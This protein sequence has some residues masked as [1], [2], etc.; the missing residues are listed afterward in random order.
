MLNVLDNEPF[1]GED[2]DAEP[3]F[4]VDLAALEAELDPVGRGEV[5]GL[6][7]VEAGGEAG[8]VGAWQSEDKFTWLL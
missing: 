4:A 7:D 6:A 8:V 2:R 3:G 5:D 1:H